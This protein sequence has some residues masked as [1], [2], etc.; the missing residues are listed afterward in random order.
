[1]NLQ[2]FAEP[3]TPETNPEDELIDV[4]KEANQLIL[5]KDKE[6][7]NLKT[8]LARANLLRQVPEDEEVEEP[9]DLNKKFT[10]AT[11]DYEIALHAVKLHEHE[12]ANPSTLPIDSQTGKHKYTLGSRA[13]DVA[14]FLKDCI[15]QSEG[16]P[17]R[18]HT[19]YKSNIGPDSHE[20]LNLYNQS[21]RQIAENNFRHNIQ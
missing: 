14:T 2:L 5:E 12:K 7:K 9:Y 3:I 10:P 16:D 1:M 11:T 6:I 18:F 21:Q 4:A 17:H 15:D 19:I 8:Q 20:A 13:D